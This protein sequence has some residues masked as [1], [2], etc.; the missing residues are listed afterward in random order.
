MSST[1]KAFINAYK[2]PARRATAPEA[3]ATSE[4]AT[5]HLAGPYCDYATAH[6]GDFS[7]AESFDTSTLSCD[8]PTAEPRPAIAP[9]PKR[10]LSEVQAEHIFGFTQRRVETNRP[11]WPEVCQGLLA[12]AADGYD[13]LI[14]QLPDGTSGT[15]VGLVGV[16][17]EAGG[18][19]TAICLALRSAALGHNVALMD[20]DLAGGQLAATLRIHHPAC[21]LSALEAGVS[22]TSIASTADDVGVDLLLAGKS[23]EGGLTSTARFRA[24]LAAGMLRRSYQH[25]FVDLGSIRPDSAETIADLAAAMGLDYLIATTT[26]RHAQSLGDA[27]AALA[28]HNL[29]F[30]G[31]VEAA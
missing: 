3:S 17:P 26:P 24:S 29:T 6:A 25:T 16:A 15:L 11:Q 9:T 1:N 28:E 23:H 12:R 13:T 4:L 27:V 20:G 19:T 5:A 31:V 22:I 7:H 10:P 30:A 18:T 8:T 21:W 2:Q 14:R